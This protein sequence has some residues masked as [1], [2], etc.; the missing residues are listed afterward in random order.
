[1]KPVIAIDGPAGA[2]KST[3]AKILA[4]RLDL[5]YLDTGAMYRAVALL[6]SRQGLGPED[7]DR[8]AEL[9]QSSV[10][11][12]GEGNPQ[13]VFLNDEDVTSAIRTPEM[14]ELAS[15]LSAHSPVRAILASRQQ[16]MIAEGGVILEG[17]DTTTVVAPHATL[18]VFLTASLEE[19]AERRL[20][21]FRDK[22]LDL[23]GEELTR[24]IADR[25]HRDYTRQ[26]SP[27]TKPADAVLVESFGKTPAEVAEEI[28]AALARVQQSEQP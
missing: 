26:D 2:G 25:D 5:R 14:G 23:T 18:K 22:G 27:L 21:E 7:G 1:M 24:Q 19:R 17:R 28:I 16:A 9:A 6:A 10:I 20:R 13:R 8:A 4:E 3:V 11:R 15:A 12:F